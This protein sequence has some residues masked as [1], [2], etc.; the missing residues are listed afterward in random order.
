VGAAQQTRDMSDKEQSALSDSLPSLKPINKITRK[1]VV[2]S[3]LELFESPS[4]LEIGVQKGKTFNSVHAREKVAVDPKFLFDYAAVAADVPGTSFHETT[5]DD[6]FGRIAA[7]DA[8]F[9]VVYIDGLHTFEQTLRDLVNSISLLKPQG[10]IIID[11]V[12]PS[13]YSASL[14]VKAEAKALIR[15]TGEISN[16][17]M[18]DVYRLVFFVE[19]FCQQFSYSTV[20]N[21]H[22]QLVMWR[23]PRQD[24]VSRNLKEIAEKAYK[25]LFVE[26]AS[27]RCNSL[28]VILDRIKAARC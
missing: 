10:V 26:A 21:N 25:D 18:G 4:Y 14:P 3:V 22:G 28:E 27:F 1:A 5:S 12:F 20:N 13:S 24:F 7:R 11:D 6:Y 17:W 9:D 8:A 16:A 23:E 15:A 19:S 2:Q